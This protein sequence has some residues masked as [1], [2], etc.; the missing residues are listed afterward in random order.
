VSLA[1]DD[2]GLGSRADFLAVP[3]ASLRSTNGAYPQLEVVGINFRLLPG[4]DEQTEKR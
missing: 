1:Q 2:E 4:A 3:L